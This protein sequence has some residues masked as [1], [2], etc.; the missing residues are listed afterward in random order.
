MRVAESL[1][2][3]E[4][5]AS[6]TGIVVMTVWIVLTHPMRTRIVAGL[7]LAFFLAALFVSASSF[8]A[9]VQ[10]TQ[11]GVVFDC[12]SALGVTEHASAGY[13]VADK[14][15]AACRS[16]AAEQVEVIAKRATYPSAGGLLCLAFIVTVAPRREKA[17][18]PTRTFAE[19]LDV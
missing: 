12:G 7:G 18:Q 3:A 5:V 1:V 10:V 6:L 9:E 4:L 17:P 16:K 11:S 13:S 19:P 14:A 8:I 2:I 15:D